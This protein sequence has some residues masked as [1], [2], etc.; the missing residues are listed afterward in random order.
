MLLFILGKCF[1]ALKVAARIYP[2]SSPPLHTPFRFLQVQVIFGNNCQSVDKL[3][4]SGL[5]QRYVRYHTSPS[6][7]I[8]NQTPVGTRVL[9]STSTCS[10]LPTIP[11]RQSE[12]YINTLMLTKTPLASLPEEWRRD[13]LFSCFHPATGQIAELLELLGI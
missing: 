12:V 9:F 11:F 2:L 8:K 1:D 4:P 13:N 5:S 6:Y 10:S 7:V 3:I